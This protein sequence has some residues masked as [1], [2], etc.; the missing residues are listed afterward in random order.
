MQLVES[1]EGCRFRN[2]SGV[3]QQVDFSGE[4]IILYW[5]SSWQMHKPGDCFLLGPI[6][7]VRRHFLRW[8]TNFPTSFK[9]CHTLC[10]SYTC[11]RLLCFLCVSQ[12]LKTVTSVSRSSSGCQSTCSRPMLQS[13]QVVQLQ[14]SS[15]MTSALGD[16]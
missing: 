14:S 6:V 2:S 13:P 1:F 16:L 3:L 15:L 8:D 10:C 12:G 9:I 5:L 4:V 11:L 7:A